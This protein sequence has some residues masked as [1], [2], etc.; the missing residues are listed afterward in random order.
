MSKFKKC[1]YYKSD[2]HIES[3]KN[4]SILGRE[5]LK[6][7][8]NQRMENYY[9]NPSKCKE[10]NVVL[11]YSK[12][13]N[14]FCSSSCSASY[15]NKNRI[16]TK[17]HKIK[18]SLALKGRTSP[19]KGKTSPLKGRVMN[20]EKINKNCIICDKL[21]IPKTTESGLLSKSKCCGSECRTK[22]KSKRGKKVMKERIKNGTHKGWQSRNKLSYPEK[23]F[24]KVL[25]NNNLFD[26]CSVN[27]KIKKR[28]LG[29]KDN[30]NYFLDFYFKEKRIDLEI[31]GKQHEFRKQ[32]DDK[33]DAL[34]VKNE[35]KVYRI[36]WKSINTKNG[37]EYIKKEIE[38]FLDFYNN[39]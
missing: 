3:I 1:D 16:V 33:R 6:S 31:D 39:Q 15:N 13:S 26:K 30:Y 4:A 22:L 35:I 18:T 23:F 34:L 24:I 10:C 37:K 36:K 29:L 14:K 2:E 12:K 7:K 11:N 32:H 8:K 25:K 27:Y 28:D 21:F 38:K 19:L 17:E 20:K 9:N 5:K